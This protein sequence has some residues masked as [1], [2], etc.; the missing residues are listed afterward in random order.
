MP[1]CDKMAAMRLRHSALVLLSVGLMTGSSLRADDGAASIAAG[2][3]ILMKREP[4]IVMAKEV[5]SISSERVLVDYDFRN[6]SNEDITTEVAFPI[7]GYTLDA[8]SFAT[9][10]LQG[11]DDFKLW[12]AGEP[13]KFITETRAF[14]GKRDITALLLSMKVDASSMGHFD[15]P[16]NGDP[17][18][19]DIDRL[20]A[21]QKKRLLSAGAMDDLPLWRVEKKYHWTQTFPAHSTIHIR[22]QYTPVLG[23]SNTIGNPAIYQG[24]HATPEYTESCPN[25]ALRNT[26]SRLWTKQHRD[27]GSPLSISY[28]SFILTT[29]NTW[30]TPIEDFTLIV[31]RP[32]EPKEKAYVSFCWDGPVT[33]V[34][35]DH[36]SAHVAGL[37][38]KKEL[39]IGYIY[40]NLEFGSIDPAL[41]HS[42]M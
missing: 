11:F 31:E 34:D 6:D 15:W 12:V 33:Q 29:A 24:K 22:H 7:P 37:V 28:V 18:V 19:P 42:P 32:H 40:D 41:P 16:A 36:F 20:T 39:M 13:A 17:T 27:E 35:A 38:P 25:P 3:V 10:K 9:P 2:G 8:D 23:N 21:S 4:R 5:L 1:T 26:L 30:K 14:V